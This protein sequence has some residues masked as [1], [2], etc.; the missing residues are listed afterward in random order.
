MHAPGE[1]TALLHRLR[2]QR[3]HLQ[4]VLPGLE[5]LL[6]TGAAMAAALSSAL[7]DLPP[8]PAPQ[9]PDLPLLDA[10]AVQ[11]LAPWLVES[12][13][14]MAPAVAALYEI[15]GFADWVTAENIDSRLLAATLALLHFD[16]PALYQHAAAAGVPAE[17]FALAL[18]DA[19]APVFTILARRLAEERTEELHGKGWCPV[20]GQNPCLALLGTANFDTSFLASSGGQRILRCSLC[21][22]DWRVSKGLCPACGVEFGGEEHPEGKHILHAEGVRH[23]RLE[24]C[25]LCGSYIPCLDLRELE[26]PPPTALALLMLLP[27]DLAA[28]NATASNS[29][30]ADVASAGRELT[31]VTPTRCNLLARCV[32]EA[33]D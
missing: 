5:D 26:S 2:S 9:D 15:P 33:C 24:C 16:G 8:H 7:P 27:L 1:L 21:D 4:A 31:P 20:C 13:R 17:V 3:P 32:L 28:L 29:T 14:R 6:E 12:A 10:D 25:S 11:A 18:Q 19:V 23:E 30:G 22:T